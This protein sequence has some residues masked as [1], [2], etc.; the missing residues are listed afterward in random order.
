MQNALA[1]IA[2]T[3]Y[4]NQLGLQTKQ[5]EM[6]IE[7]DFAKR[8]AYENINDPATAIANMMAMYQQKGI[9]FTQSLQTKLSEFANS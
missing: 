2:L 1:G 7:A 8:Q 3:Q 9:P 5:A 6:Q 4:Q